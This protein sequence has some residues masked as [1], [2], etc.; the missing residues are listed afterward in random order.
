V[1][2]GE[3]VGRHVGRRRAEHGWKVDRQEMCRRQNVRRNAEGACSQVRCVCGGEEA[4]EGSVVEGGGLAGNQC[5]A[6]Q[7]KGCQ[8]GVRK[9]PRVRAATVTAVGRAGR[10]QQQQQESRN[11]VCSAGKYINVTGELQGYGRSHGRHRP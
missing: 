9:E 10:L 4:G 1:E 2:E 6:V 3:V 5:T 7:E 11:Y 8:V